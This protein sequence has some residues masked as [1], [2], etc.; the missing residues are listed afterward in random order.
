[1]NLAQCTSFHC[2]PGIKEKYLLEVEDLLKQYSPHA[3][4]LDLEDS[5][6][7]SS[8]EKAR[9]IIS[10]NYDSIRVFCT[11]KKV[12][13]GLRINSRNTK[14]Q[15][16]DIQLLKKYAFDFVDIPKVES[17]SDIDY[18]TNQCDVSI[19]AC[20]ETLIGM[21]NI[22][23]IF[24]KLNREKDIVFI[25]HEDPCADYG[26]ERPLDLS[27]FNP[28]SFFIMTVLTKCREYR[29]TAIDGPS[30][31]FQEAYMENVRSECLLEKSWGISGKITIHPRQISCV[32]DVFA[33]GEY[34]RK[35][36]EVVQRF[37]E[38]KDGSSV[39]LDDL[40]NMMD[41]PSLRMYRNILSY[42]S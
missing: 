22:D 18:V 40:G 35:A 30:R 39:A 27:I 29:L 31:E 5:V 21:K 19:A 33:K 11:G 23:D 12:A 17:S 37:A 3:I 14:W 28:L 1:M 34:M 15:N 26:I 42:H 10:Q 32:N 25:G 7:E 24:P 8:K 6:D 36:A 16:G 38:L 20:I 2:I 4:I 41:K 13:L 9:N